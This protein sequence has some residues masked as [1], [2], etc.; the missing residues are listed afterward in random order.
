MDDVDY[1][2]H[3]H[4]AIKSLATESKPPANTIA[5]LSHVWSSV[6]LWLPLVGIHANDASARSTAA[7]SGR[8]PFI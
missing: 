2:E 3:L 4:L 8:A 7:Y 1:R 6:G 5:S